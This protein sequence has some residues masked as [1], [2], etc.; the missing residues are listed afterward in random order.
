[1]RDRLL[2]PREHE[3]RRKT[4]HTPNIGSWLTR[5]DTEAYVSR[6]SFLALPCPAT[7]EDNQKVPWEEASC[8][9][10]SK[11]TQ[12]LRQQRRRTTSIEKDEDSTDESLN[13]TRARDTCHT[14]EPLHVLLPGRK[15]AGRCTL[16]PHNL[17]DLRPSTV[18][19]I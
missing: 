19:V 5:H 3:P 13:A 16:P 7:A 1:M 17:P 10:C 18:G 11:R 2:R 6:N 14:P 12:P 15:S 9:S 8:T 4:D